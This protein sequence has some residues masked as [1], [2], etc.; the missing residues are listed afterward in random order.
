MNWEKRK[1]RKQKVKEAL[2]EELTIAFNLCDQMKLLFQKTPDG[3]IVLQGDE[4]DFFIELMV[5]GL[6]VKDIVDLDESDC[7]CKLDALMTQGC[8]CG[9]MGEEK[10]NVQST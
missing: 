2:K 1:A 7:R 10:K 6:I 8:Q 3:N 5:S 9:A 4:W